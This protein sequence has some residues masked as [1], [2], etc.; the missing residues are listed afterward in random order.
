MAGPA[1]AG[2]PGRRRQLSLRGRGYL[3]RDLRLTRVCVVVGGQTPGA[4]TQCLVRHP[5]VELR[6][7]DL[8]LPVR[9]GRG[10]PPA[11]FVRPTGV[12]T[13]PFLAVLQVR[14]AGA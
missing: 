8:P 1:L 14:R 13:A 10:G 2:D 9:S 7:R 12:A 11:R 3:G 4:D 6:P 5:E